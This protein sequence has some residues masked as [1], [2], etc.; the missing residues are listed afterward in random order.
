MLDVIQSQFNAQI[1]NSKFELFDDSSVHMICLHYRAIL[2]VHV[3]VHVNRS[4]TDFLE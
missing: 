3:H 2:H 1:G 4:V